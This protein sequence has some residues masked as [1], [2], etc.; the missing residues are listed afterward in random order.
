MVIAQNCSTVG[1]MSNQHPLLL[2]RMIT[3]RMWQLSN[4]I[5][6]ESG[7]PFRA[8]RV[9]AISSP[10][11]S[12]ALR[13]DRRRMRGGD[14]LFV[15]SAFVYDQVDEGILTVHR[16]EVYHAN[17][18]TPELEAFTRRFHIDPSVGSMLRRQKDRVEDP[19]GYSGAMN[20]LQSIKRADR[21]LDPLSNHTAG[22]GLRAVFQAIKDENAGLNEADSN[23]EAY[24]HNT[25][26]AEFN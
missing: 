19:V 10:V 15:A 13:V 21:S 26:V 16:H 4:S 1:F 6:E 8:N 14:I 22:I 23:E 11:G 17:A 9:Q 24:F 2:D 12:L 25:I 18:A 3:P 5:I 20:V 7:T